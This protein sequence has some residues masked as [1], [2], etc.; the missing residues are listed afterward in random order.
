MEIERGIP[1]PVR[2]VNRSYPFAD[3]EVG[4]SFALGFD[5]NLRNRLS[6]AASLAGR[7]LGRRFTTRVVEEDGVRVVRC[8]RVS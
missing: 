6:S 1:V 2:A 3:M 7:R 4:D 8:W 5:A